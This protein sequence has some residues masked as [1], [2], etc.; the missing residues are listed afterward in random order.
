[1]SN[2]PQIGPRGSAGDSGAGKESVTNRQALGT[3]AFIVVMLTVGLPL[4]IFLW[5]LALA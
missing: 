3:L 1:M 5:K 4:T 2:I